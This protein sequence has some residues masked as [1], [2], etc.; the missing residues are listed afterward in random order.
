M[1]AGALLLVSGGSGVKGVAPRC[2]KEGP[3][4]GAEAAREGREVGYGKGSEVRVSWARSVLTKSCAARLA[5]TSISVCV[6]VLGCAQARSRC[7]RGEVGALVADRVCGMCGLQL[8]SRGG[9]AAEHGAVAESGGRPGRR[10][11]GGTRSCAQLAMLLAVQRS[12][13]Q[14]RG[15]CAELPDA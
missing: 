4:G 10:G 12:G 15:A 1:A 11:L 5:C 13:L 2:A 3:V 6:C 7:A 14:M 8:A 9:L